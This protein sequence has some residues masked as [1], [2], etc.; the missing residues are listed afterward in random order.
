MFDIKFMQ[1]FIHK[2][3]QTCL[4]LKVTEHCEY[5]H[6]LH[7]QRKF[8]ELRISYKSKKNYLHEGFNP[9]I[10]ENDNKF[11][12]WS[13]KFSFSSQKVSQTHP[14]HQLPSAWRIWCSGHSPGPMQSQTMLCLDP[15]SEC[16][17]SYQNVQSFWPKRQNTLW[18]SA[19][20][21]SFSKVELFNASKC[22]QFNKIIELALI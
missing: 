20:Q 15:P 16:I 8:W 7:R 17:L 5:L 22:G 6:N 11:T 19:S 13:S 1:G 18:T 12:N 14:L 3:N 4:R 2:T 21:K 9:G 10:Q